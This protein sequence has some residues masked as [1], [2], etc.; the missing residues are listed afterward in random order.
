M[1][2]MAS[3]S[4]AEDENSRVTLPDRFIGKGNA[5]SQQSAMKLTELGPR[6]TLEIFKVEQGVNE[7]DVLYHKF[8]HK[9]PAEAAKIKAKI[10]KSKRLKEDRKSTQEANV[11]RKREAEAEKRQAKIDRKRRKIEG[12]TGED[13]GGV[14]SDSDDEGGRVADDDENQYAEYDG[15]EHDGEYD[16]EEDAD[17]DQE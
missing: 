15:I 16:G 1:N 12:A 6:L 8:V 14:D 7:G 17:S 4:E 5:K 2:G 3:D 13:E 10:E 9:T 11:K